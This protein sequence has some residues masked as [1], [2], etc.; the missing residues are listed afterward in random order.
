MKKVTKKSATKKI[1][2]KKA[3]AKKIVK[4]DEYVTIV[5]PGN[6]RIEEKCPLTA[7]TVR[8][9]A[10]D[11]SFA[12]STIQDSAGRDMMPSIFPLTTAQTIYINRLEVPKKG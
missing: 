2:A 9:I 8:K 6:K 10:K 5:L 12:T 7:N 4:K 1:V 11:A 3:V